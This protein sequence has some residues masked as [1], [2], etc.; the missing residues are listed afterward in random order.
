MTTTYD[1]LPSPPGH[2]V[3]HKGPT[4]TSTR[5]AAGGEAADR[6]LGATS[7][8]VKTDDHPSRGRS[9]AGLAA[10]LEPTEDDLAS[11]WE[12][13]LADFRAGEADDT[14]RAWC[15]AAG[16]LASAIESIADYL[17]AGDKKGLATTVRRCRAYDIALHEITGGRTMR[18]IHAASRGGAR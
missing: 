2:T 16:Y 15:H 18:Q 9:R 8:T 1:D 7:R 14:R 3:A 13:G 17:L 12:G 11:A 10:A 4:G 5:Q 6:A